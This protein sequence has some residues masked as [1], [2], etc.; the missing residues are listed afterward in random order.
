LKAGAD[1]ASQ[2]PNYRSAAHVRPLTVF[3]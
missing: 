3:L 1:L 2:E